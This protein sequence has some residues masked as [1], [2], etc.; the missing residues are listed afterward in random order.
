MSQFRFGKR[1]VRL[2]LVVFVLTVVSVD[3]L[4]TRGAI[5]QPILI[6]RMKFN[7]RLLVL[8]ISLSPLTRILHRQSLIRLPQIGNLIV[9]RIVRIRL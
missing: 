7:L 9:Q 3:L 6:L 4:R 2:A 1:K 5:W 8:S